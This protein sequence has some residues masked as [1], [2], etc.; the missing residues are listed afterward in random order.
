[1]NPW[2]GPRAF[3][4]IYDVPNWK[5]WNPRLGAA[6]DLFGNGKTALKFSVGRYVVK[7][8]TDEFA[9]GLA[10]P[11]QRSINYSLRSWTDANG[12]Y[13]P[14]CNLGNFGANGECGANTS[15]L[16]AAVNTTNFDPAV[17]T[18]YGKRDSNWDVSAEV[19]HELRKGVGVTAGYYFNNG[20]YTR[21][22]PNN[23]FAFNSK[24]RVT[25]NLL[26]SPADYDAYCIKAPL[27]R[28]LPG[29][30]G[31]P[32]C[33]LANLQPEKVGLVSNLITS[34]DK[35]GDFNTRNDF[36]S[37]T[38]DA[39]LVRGIRLGG[40]ADTGRSLADRCFI[41]NSQQDL[42]NCRTVTPFKAQTQ[43]KAHGIFPMPAKFVASFIFQNLSGPTYNA[44]YAVQDA[45]A[46]PSLGRPLSGG[47]VDVPLVAPWTLFEPRISRLDLR[48]TKNLRVNRFQVQLNLDVY[49]A[50][51]ANSIQAVNNRYGDGWRR[52]L[53]ILDARLFQ[54]GGQVS[55]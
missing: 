38:I 2:L 31:Y 47:S 40:G 41:V 18:G 43:L 39:R 10:N 7:M 32:V 3:D 5:D 9:G 4:P 8:S 22:D 42:L 49:N 25:K 37:A 6:Y 34:V 33:G 46:L 44:T 17:L 29:G 1:V 14:D 27:D 15:P 19:Q 20:G 48:L 11:I 55:F 52:P 36:F 53:E 26:T 24:V 45:D 50:L 16:G 35:F 21:S 51:N 23:P 13:V 30:G 54:I 28:N 12:D